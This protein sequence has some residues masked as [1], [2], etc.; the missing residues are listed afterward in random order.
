MQRGARTGEGS[1]LLASVHA[2]SPRPS[3]EAA[4][5]F[6]GR[7]RIAQALLEHVTLIDVGWEV[8]ERA[9][10]LDPEGMRSLDAV[11]L[12]TALT[13]A[14]DLDGIVTDDARLHDAAI[15]IGLSVIVSA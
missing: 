13:L 11:P 7:A 14:E 5:C 3:G 2:L 8:C 6:C 15:A 4:T 12:A 9:G 10:L 1:P